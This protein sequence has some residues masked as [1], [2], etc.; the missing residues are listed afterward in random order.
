VCELCRFTRGDLQLM[1]LLALSTAR[2]PTLV[3]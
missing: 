3:K 2:F 1:T